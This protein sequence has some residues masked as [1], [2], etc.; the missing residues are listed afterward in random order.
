MD[1]LEALIGYLTVSWDGLLVLTGDV[2]IDMLKPLDSRTV[3]YQSILDVFRLKQIVTKPTHITRTSTTLL[4]P[5][6]VNLSQNITYTDV[7]PC[8]I[9]SDHNAPFACINVRVPRF[10]PRFKYIRNERHFNANAF[11]EDFSS[12]PL[13]IVYGL[14]SPD[15]MVDVMNSLIK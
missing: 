2:N 13:N 6:I 1:R 15:D 8:S 12:L 3:K 11:K 5:I 9:V 10:Q 4:D 7:I 14:E